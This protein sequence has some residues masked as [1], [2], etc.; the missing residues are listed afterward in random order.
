MTCYSTFVTLWTVRAA[1]LLYGLSLAAWIV[2]RD[3]LFR[4]LWSLGFVCY[5]GH[6]VAAFSFHYGWSHEA[7]YRETAQ[8]TAD[9]FRIRW[10]GGLYFNYAFTAVWAGDLLWLW[11]DPAGYRRRGRAG[12]AVHWFTAFM[13]F[14]GA[15]VFASGWIRWFSLMSAITL[16]ILWIQRRRCS[17]TSAP[18][19]RQT[20][21]L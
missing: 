1:C 16:A 4:L 10:G 14:N 2:R 19:T 21:P 3:G 11:I 7:A 9:L 5:L 8:Q 13:F 12:L 17:L 15:V 18:E 6:V 20:I